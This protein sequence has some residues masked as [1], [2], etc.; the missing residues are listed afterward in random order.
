MERDSINM[1]ASIRDTPPEE[2]EISIDVR[3][4]IEGDI[5]VVQG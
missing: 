2:R 5:K 4:A 3:E 1:D